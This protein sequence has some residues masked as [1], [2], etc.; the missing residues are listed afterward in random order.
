M[1]ARI[2]RGGFGLGSVTASAGTAFTAVVPPGGAREKARITKFVYTA[3]NTAH[4]VNVLKCQGKTSASAAASASQ[5]DIVLEDVSS[6]D[7]YD[8]G[9]TTETLA[10]SDWLVIKHTDGSHE[11][12]SV[13]SISGSTVTLASNLV[14]AVD[15]GAPVFKMYELARPSSGK[16]F[17]AQVFIPPASATT[18]IGSENPEAAVA[19]SRFGEPLLIHSNNASHQGTLVLVQGVYSSV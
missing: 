17:P 1:D 15:A 18:S 19:V 2:Y 16:G 13:S 7:E 12:Y 8:G 11:A 4:S 6:V 10:A 5:A 3:G 14:K 9:S